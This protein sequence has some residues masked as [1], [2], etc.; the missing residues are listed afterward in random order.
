MGTSM[1]LGKRQIT[2]KRNALVDL[3]VSQRRMALYVS[4]LA[5]RIEKI[6]D[7]CIGVPDPWR[8][9]TELDSICTMSK[10]IIS[11]TIDELVFLPQWQEGAK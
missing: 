2:R 10:S 4:I 9:I 6:E 1:A 5:D 3:I 8:L 7:A 11:R